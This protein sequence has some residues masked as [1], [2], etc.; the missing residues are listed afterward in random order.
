MI[1]AITPLV[2]TLDEA[3]NIAR[4]LDKLTWA[5]RIV[6]V[7]SGS[8][9]GTIEILKRYPQVDRFDRPFD[10][11]AEQC[12][13]GL[14]QV[15]TEWV[16]SLDADYELSDDLVRELAE[17]K[18]QTAAGFRASFVYR[19][20]GRSLR[21]TIY[22]PRI[23]LYR[24][25][26]ASYRNEGHGH[27]LALDGEVRDLGSVIYHDDRKPLSRWLASQQRYAE[28][29]ANHLL[30]AAPGSLSLSGRLR[31]MAW[32]TPI[33]VFPYVLIA[34]RCV[35]DGWHGW[36][37]SLQRLV[38]EILIALNIIDQKLRHII[39]QKLRRSPHS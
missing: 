33:L 32:P 29:E 4:T 30:A 13:F 7:D 2:I 21:G 23:V 9:D 19:I 10:S 38:W 35:L 28:M 34:K 36:Y 26:G 31:R 1:D 18:P 17:L 8:V 37:Y 6:V 20:D 12:N 25:R 22:P 15:Q 3:P 24:V 14:A 16:L 27:R 5:R 39:D 11:F